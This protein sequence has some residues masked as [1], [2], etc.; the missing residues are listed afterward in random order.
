MRKREK[1]SLEMRNGDI[2]RWEDSK[3][4]GKYWEACAAA[5]Q[6]VYLAIIFFRSKSSKEKV[7]RM[8]SEEQ[9]KY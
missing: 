6:I 7:K 5:E 1:E 3:K 8:N 9:I 2:N 4:N